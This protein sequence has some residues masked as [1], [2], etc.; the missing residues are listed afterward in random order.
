MARVLAYTS[1]AARDAGLERAAAVVCHSGMGIVQKAELAPRDTGE[2]M[3][4]HA[5]EPHGG[6]A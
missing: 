1:P 2:R 3:V 4:V 6:P 5:A